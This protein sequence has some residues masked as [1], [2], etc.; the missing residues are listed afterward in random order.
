MEVHYNRA[1]LSEIVNDIKGNRTVYE[2]AKD[3]KLSVPVI[4]KMLGCQL[5]AV[6]STLTLSK[7]TSRTSLTADDVINACGP[8][9]EVKEQKDNESEIITSITKPIKNITKSKQ[10][11]NKITI[12]SDSIQEKFKTFKDRLNYETQF[13]SEKEAKMLI[14]MLNISRGK[15]TY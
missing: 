6:P 8:I 9:V 13:L 4:K 3:T 1:K 14:N 5:K 10:E 2:F 12:N 15:R 11:I 7:L